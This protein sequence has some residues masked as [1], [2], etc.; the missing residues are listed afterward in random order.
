MQ[1]LSGLFPSHLALRLKEFR[2]RFQHYL[3]IKVAGS[4]VDET[5]ILLAALFASEAGD[6]FECTPQEAC[7]VPSP[8]PNGRGSRAL[9]RNPHRDG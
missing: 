5:W 6:F 7:R 8:F 4:V 3:M 9:P 1:A 2:A